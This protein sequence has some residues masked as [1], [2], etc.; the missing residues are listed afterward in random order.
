MMR[1]E[2][3]ERWRERCR[4]RGQRSVEKQAKGSQIHRGGTEVEGWRGREVEEGMGMR[5]SAVGA[6]PPVPLSEVPTF[7]EEGALSP[8]WGHQAHGGAVR[9]GGDSC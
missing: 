3:I 9:F 7:L 5:E 1:N 8:P 6:P 2:D 4:D